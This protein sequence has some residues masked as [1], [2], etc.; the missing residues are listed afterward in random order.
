MQGEA[1]MTPFGRYRP[2]TVLACLVLTAHLAAQESRPLRQI[3]D[4]ETRSAWQREKITPAPKADDSTFL[5]RVYL[6]LLGDLPKPDEVQ[7]FTADTDPKKREK[8]ID[9]LLADPR[10][11]TQQMNVWDQV[12]FGRRPQNIDA[13]RKR[14]AFKK[15]LEDKFAKNVPYDRWVRDLMIG[16]EDGSELFHV[17]YSRQPEEETVAVSRVF[18]GTQLQCARCHDHPFDPSLT[19]KDFYGMAGFFVRLMVFDNGGTAQQKRYKIGE[20]ASGDVLF[21]GAVKDQKPGQKGEPVK[22]KYLGGPAQTEPALPASFK[23]PDYR[24]VKSLPKP[25]FSRKEQLADWLTKADNPYFARAAVNRV[26]AQFMGRGFVHPVDDLG[27]KNEPSHPELLKAMT[28][29]FVKNKFDLKPLVREIV[30]SD[31]YQLASTG[32]GTEALPKWYE[33]ARVRPLSAEELISSIATV[34]NWNAKLPNI[35]DDYFIRYFGEPT[36][37]M[38]E[39]QGSLQEHLFLNHGEQVRQF[40]RRKTGNTTDAMLTSKE[41]WEKRVDQLFLTV[42][43]RLPKESERKKFVEYLSSNPKPDGQVEEAIWVLLNTAEFR[44]NH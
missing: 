39:F 37:G 27:G 33:R 29:S 2:V 24:T 23:E 30:N 43:S 17:Q 31:V 22:P 8:L 7:K 28:E 4:N 38:G 13:T 42:L 19:Q 32:T 16:E 15:W 35:M 3:I 36:N 14:D 5:R 6:D 44:F 41:P 21:T 10:Y 25:P 1:W 12:L 11:A 20:K 34:T 9:R 40:I 18:M 26:W